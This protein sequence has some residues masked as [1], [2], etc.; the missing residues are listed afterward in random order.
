MMEDLKKFIRDIPDFPKAGIIFK[1]IT[2]L[3]G[4]AIAFKRVIDHLAGRY[5]GKRIQ[6]VVGV[7]ARG[8]IFAGALAY[9]LGVGMVPA[10]KPGK[11][12]YSTTR[13][14]Y[15]LEYGTDS[16]EMHEDAIHRGERVVVLDDVLA[17]GGTLS[18]V[19]RMVERLGGE[20]VEVATLIELSFLHGREKL[21]G[22]S[23][24]TILTF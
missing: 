1:D 21:E 19:C 12:P 17:T 14:T 13:E 10:R 7:E 18:A 5:K 9:A 15:A 23:Y 11:L 3:L 4:D 22:R 2:P 8:L 16:L 6:K 20:L 24:Y